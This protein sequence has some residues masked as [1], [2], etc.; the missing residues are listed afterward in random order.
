MVK[1]TLIPLFLIFMLNLSFAQEWNSQF[2][3]PVVIL[4]EYNPWE[5]VIGSDV[6]TIAIY[7]SG[8]IIYQLP[9]KKMSKFYTVNLDSIQTQNLINSLGITDS[10]SKMTA[11]VETTSLT[12]QPTNELILNFDQPN[13]KGVY[14]DLRNSNAA[15]A[16]TPSYF[17]NVFD[18]LINYKNKEATEWLPETIEVLLTDYNHSVETPKNWPENWPNLDSETTIRRSE[19]LYSV[20]L[21]KSN[22]EEFL[23]LLNSLE[24]NQ[25]VVLNGKKFSV[26]YRLPFPNL[27]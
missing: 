19:F 5:M 11:Y 22:F 8:N 23:T 16:K 13:T 1:K 3:S 2:G 7:K 14:G 25:A 15:R 9:K 10:L 27:K 26:S 12:D 4:T 24:E 20:Y 18:K 21:S 6:P 17:L